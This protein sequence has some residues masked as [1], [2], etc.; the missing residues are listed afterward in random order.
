MKKYLFILSAT[1]FVVFTFAANIPK[2]SAQTLE[3]SADT[4]MDRVFTYAQNNGG[5]I[6]RFE[7][8]VYT[9]FH[10]DSNVRNF[11]LKLLPHSI[12]FP[13]GKRHIFGES[14]TVAGLLTGKDIYEQLRDRDLGDLLL[15]PEN[16]LRSGGDI[17]LDDMSPGQLSQKLGVK[18]SPSPN[19][20]GG[21]IRAVIT[22]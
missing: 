8:I 14:I 9:K 15:F 11:L 20:G 1:L 6:G 2:A 19:N 10:I 13:K 18:A 16:A 22:G 12:D 17:F 5:H 7:N 3:T 4:L 21:F